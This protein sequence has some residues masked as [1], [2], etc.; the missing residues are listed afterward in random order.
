MS[1]KLK[2]FKHMLKF[3]MY[4]RLA[5]HNMIKSSIQYLKA[6]TTIS[7]NHVLNRPGYVPDVRYNKRNTLHI[8]IILL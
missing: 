4:V 5:H 2:L 1:L 8:R 7:Q 3:E 6:R